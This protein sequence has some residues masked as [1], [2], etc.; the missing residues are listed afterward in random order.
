MKYNLII[1]ALVGLLWTVGVNAQPTP[2]EIVAPD[3]VEEV[4]PGDDD[5]AE[6]DAI[7]EIVEGVADVVDDIAGIKAAGKD[8]TA[9]AFAVAALIASLL[10]IGL[11]V[12]KRWGPSWF[13]RGDVLRLV[14]ALVGLGAF[15]AASIVPGVSWTE[16]MI[17]ALGGPG[18][19]V[20]TEL[21]KVIAPNKPKAT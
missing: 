15:V 19:I 20:I 12:L 14:C 3:T 13:K 9:I 4:E 2:T 10:K 21:S 18:A 17:L 5:S 1:L 11:A 8:R 7:E 6:P 16:A